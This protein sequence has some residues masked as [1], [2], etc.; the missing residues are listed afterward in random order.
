MG[1]TRRPEFR[2]WTP[3][4][5]WLGIEL[6]RRGLWAQLDGRPA[7]RV[8]L[9]ESVADDDSVCAAHVASEHDT[10][11]V[12]HLTGRRGA[13][14]W[15][16]DVVV[17]GSRWR[18]DWRLELSRG[19]GET[20]VVG[21]GEVPARIE[22]AGSEAIV[23]RLVTRRRALRIPS[24]LGEVVAKVEDRAFFRHTRQSSAQPLA[25]LDGMRWAAPT[26][27][28]EAP[29]WEIDLGGTFFVP[30][31]VVD[32]ASVPPDASLRVRGFS[33]PGP[34]GE[35]PAG[36]LTVTRSLD[37]LAADRDGLTRVALATG[38]V[39]R[40]VQVALYGKHGQDVSLAV[41]GCEI[42][43]AS[44]WGETLRETWRRALALFRDRV[45]VV[46]REGEEGPFEPRL[47]FG[48][49]AALVA[50]LAC[51]LARRLEPADARV[52]F[53]LATA[54]RT[55]WLL[56][57]LAA[58]ERGY[59]VV[60]VSPQE[61]DDRLT[62]ILERCRPAVMLVAADDAERL[63]RLARQAC[64]AMR[65][66]VVCDAD[67]RDIPY[68]SSGPAWVSFEALVRDGERGEAPAVAARSED[69]LYTLLFTSGSTG[70]P[71]G[72]MRS[73]RAFHALLPS[74]GVPQPA[75]HL[76]FQPL[77]H[78]SERMY[79][80]AV[81]L[82]GGMVA[83]SRGA[84][85]LRGELRELEPTELGS[86]PRLFDVLHAEFLRRVREAEQAPASERAALTGRA[87]GSARR[88]F[89][90]RLTVLSVGSAPV[91]PEVL[92]FLREAF[93]DIWVLEGYGTTE[94]G[95]I[96]SDGQIA[97]GVAVRL[98]PVAGDEAP[99]DAAGPTRGEI[100]VRSPH[101]IEGYFGDPAA[102][103]AALDGEGFF[104]TGDLGER[105]ADGT[106]RVIG[107]R[108]S[109]VKLAHGEFV[110]PERIEGALATAVVVDRVLAHA[111]PGATGVAVL[112]VPRREE[113]AAMLAT[114]GASLD[115]LV[116][117][118][119]AAP[120]VVAALRQHG[121]R[122]GLASYELPAGV[123]LVATSPSVADGTLTASGKLARATLTG[124]HAG[125]LAAC[126]ATGAHLSTGSIQAGENPAGLSARMARAASSVLG[127]VV[128]VDEPLVDTLDSL[129]AASLLA[130]LTESL[131]RAVP[132]VDWFASRTLAELGARLERADERPFVS[133]LAREVAQE[134]S[135]PG[136]GRGVDASTVR[137]LRTVLL[138]GA[139]GFLGGHLLEELLAATTLDV[140]CLVR[141]AS[142]EEATRR[143]VAACAAQGL[144]GVDASEVRAG[145]V[146][147][148]RVRVVAGDLAAERLGLTE[149]RF[150]ALAASVDAV[151]HAGAVV[152]WL[153]PYASLRGANVDGTR[154]MVALAALG[155]V[156]PLHLVST[157]STAPEDGDEE[158]LLSTGAA[159]ASSPYALSKWLAE[160]LVRG[161]GS[162]GLPVAI[163]RP[164]MIAPHSVR[165][166]PNPT[167]FLHRYLV[168]SARL[169][170]YLDL[171]WARL[172]MTP[173]D[174]VARAVVAL[175]TSEPRGGA[176]AHLVNIDRSM[177]YAELGRAMVA[178]GVTM[179]PSD[180]AS[181]RRALVAGGDE[182]LGA[183]GAY[184]PEAGFGLAMG[185][186]PS[187]R[188]QERLAALGV[189][190]PVIDRA[191]IG[192]YVE[193]LASRGL[194]S[195]RGPR[196]G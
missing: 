97:P 2:H 11:L 176:T 23:G 194:V 48:E 161:A 66:V 28:E 53:V 4:A 34:N 93:S 179:A 42:P 154:T 47:R 160:R 87:W 98:V 141:G 17:A 92:G 145:P 124:R 173:V 96:A 33:Y 103:A 121:R 50:R 99:S 164:G 106:V 193:A 182:G 82:Q 110:A 101:V 123:V 7:Q 125:A 100:W 15:L 8:A 107:R 181:F 185:P 95:T 188:S 43:G 20:W 139:T 189:Q 113:L 187:R 52:F 25:V 138:T 115:E 29:F 10:H 6:A 68:E 86:V 146:G 111:A 192:R 61:P 89:G 157:I 117:H 56:A 36:C 143:L 162:Q 71:K 114:P 120:A 130:A 112:V 35:P 167:D 85:H 32:L 122:A 63:T 108:Q 158:T 44:P 24:P 147:A 70:A 151:L 109:A 131:G 55:E 75:V 118:P 177:S 59:V 116:A 74:Y 18:S 165:G 128:A 22:R 127:R 170:L 26:E 163:Y 72:A 64:P 1:S 196:R 105:A 46:G 171:P 152:S 142:D 153:A 40:R 168:G 45:M 186:W 148:G 57:D 140:V 175:M 3:D 49:A 30:E 31:I 169:G 41:A 14:V 172:D 79:L 38:W 13:L 84:A 5:A 16:D 19:P 73:Y 83:F 144:A 12:L 104:R 155:A 91:S 159:L 132:L 195:V 81:L 37:G 102:T 178:A 21:P 190:A 76:S 77:S 166:T 60:P 9:S 126:V 133:A 174:F 65:L 180:Y 51:G 27:S 135:R 149:A 191:I 183:L 80:P 90:E 134:L 54:N 119:A 78:V 94:V 156:R 39:T 58:V 137:P 150:A 67:R 62:S 88:A 184:F 129:G 136:L 69:D